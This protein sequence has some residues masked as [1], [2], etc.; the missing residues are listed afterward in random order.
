V[1][2]APQ[3]AGILSLAPFPDTFVS[4]PSADDFLSAG[5]LLQ[6]DVAFEIS[7]TAGNVLGSAVESAVVPADPTH[8]GVCAELVDAPA[9][10]GGTV[11]GAY[12]D[13]RFFQG[14]Y[15]AEI[16]T[17]EQVVLDEG[18]IDL[19]GRQGEGNDG[20]V[21][22]VNDFAASFESDFEPE[23]VPGPVPT[24]SPSPGP[25]DAQAQ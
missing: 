3:T 13:V 8:A 20:D 23:P 4:G 18:S 21:F 10:G 11:T 14:F 12:K 15:E 6:L 16:T 24:P 25:G 17:P 7:S 1:A 9:P 22:E 19:Q 2:I 5:Q